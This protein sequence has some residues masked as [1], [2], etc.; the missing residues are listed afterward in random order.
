M[1]LVLTRIPGET[2]VT[3]GPV[4]IEV[5]RVEGKHVVLRLT[6]DRS[7]KIL[8]GELL[9]GEKDERAK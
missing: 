2:I 4:T 7:V 8:R 5:A 3:D 1:A 9:K 6:A